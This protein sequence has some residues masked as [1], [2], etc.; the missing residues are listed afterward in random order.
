MADATSFMLPSPGLSAT[1]FPNKGTGENVKI[2][3]LYR[4]TGDSLGPPYGTKT[5]VVILAIHLRLTELKFY[6][7]VNTRHTVMSLSFQ[8]D[9]SR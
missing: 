1:L 2:A 7:P 8:T 4:C 6:G 9:S 5:A 3:P